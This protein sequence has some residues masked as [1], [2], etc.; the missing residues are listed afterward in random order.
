MTQKASLFIIVLLTA[1]TLASQ[2]V[3]PSG[4]QRDLTEDEP[5]LKARRFFLAIVSSVGNRLTGYFAFRNDF[6]GPVVL[7][8]NTKSDGD[9]WPDVRI[10]VAKGDGSARTVS[11]A[12]SALST[13]TLI[14]E[15]GKT[16]K[17]L[18]LL[19]ACQPYLNE[20]QTGEVILENGEVATFELKDL[21]PPPPT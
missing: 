13:Q 11:G 20:F 4:W 16:A 19:D 17:L 1:S 14:V 3:T 15:P 8:G 6:A 7:H 9:F 12:P 2:T 18:I 10:Q 21:C 5:D